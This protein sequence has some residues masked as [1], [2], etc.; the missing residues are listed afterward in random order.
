MDTRPTPVRFMFPHDVH[1][2]KAVL[3]QRYFFNF[4]DTRGDPNEVWSCFL[5]EDPR[6]QRRHQHSRITQ[7]VFRLRCTRV[8]C[9]QLV[10]DHRLVRRFLIEKHRGHCYRKVRW[11][12]GVTILCTLSCLSHCNNPSQLA[13]S[14]P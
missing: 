2:L 3:V 7:R 10:A 4:R 6:A 11:E 13:N 5:G 9:T 14:A 8:H 12:F 1:A